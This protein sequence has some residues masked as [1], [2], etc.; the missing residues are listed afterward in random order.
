[1]TMLVAWT[2][3]DSRGPS[4]I[5]LASDSRVGW[6]P[7]SRWDAGRKLFA[8]RNS[9]DLFGYRGEALLPAHILGQVTELADHGLLFDA[10]APAAERHGELVAAIEVSL[11]QRRSAPRADFNIVHAARDG[12]VMASHFSIWKSHFWN[13]GCV[14]DEQIAHLT[15]TD[16]RAS[17]M[18]LAIGSGSEAYKRQVERWEASDQRRTSRAYFT[19]LFDALATEADPQSGGAPQLAGLYRNGKGPDVWGDLER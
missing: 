2:A 5:Y 18:L 6:G 15:L 10:A 17:R 19:A 1:M 8:C 13:G 16:S 4:S 11:A 9:P 14:S 3:T 12:S 7:R